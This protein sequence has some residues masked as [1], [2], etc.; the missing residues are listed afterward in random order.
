MLPLAAVQM[1]VTVVGATISYG[2]LAFVGIAEF[3][4]NWGTMV[5]MAKIFFKSVNSTTI[6]WLQFVAPAAALSLFAGA[7]YMVSRGLHQVAEP[8]LRRR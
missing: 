4:L 6:P 7:F 2:F 5:Y 1:T 3:D 8:R